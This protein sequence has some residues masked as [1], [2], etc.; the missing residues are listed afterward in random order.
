MPWVLDH[1]GEMLELEGEASPLSGCASPRDAELVLD[2]KGGETDAS[3]MPSPSPCTAVSS[4]GTSGL[5]P[6]EGL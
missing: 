6:Q 4:V 5:P 2:S 1:Q 3:H